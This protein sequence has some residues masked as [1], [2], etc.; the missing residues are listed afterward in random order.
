MNVRP[1][2][3][4]IFRVHFEQVLAQLVGLFVTGKPFRS[5]VMQPSSLLGPVITYVENEIWIF[6]YKLGVNDANL[7]SC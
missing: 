6:F 7:K 5:S 1:A 4:S 3:Y 2:M